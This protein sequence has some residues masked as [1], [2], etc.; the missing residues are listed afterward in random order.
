M[1]KFAKFA[2]IYA[3]GGCGYGA[4]EL[5]FRGRTHWSMLAA[6]GL[7]ACL[8]CL[9]AVRPRPGRI[10]KW[11]IGGAVITAVEFVSGLILNIGLGWDVWSYADRPMNIMGQICPLFS[12]YWVLLSAPVMT[13]AELI[14]RPR[15]RRRDRG[16]KV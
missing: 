13:A 4:V 7:C 14:E 10:V 6:G 3:V 15:T 8:L 9:I 16:A 11:L 12:L 1:K 5:A 2:G